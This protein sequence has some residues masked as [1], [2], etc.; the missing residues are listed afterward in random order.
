MNKTKTILAF[1]A[2]GLAT[3]LL[4]LSLLNSYVFHWMTDRVPLSICFWAMLCLAY[5]LNGMRVG[6]VV[7]AGQLLALV[8]LACGIVS[9]FVALPG[10][11]NQTLQVLC[12]V[13][14]GAVCSSSIIDTL[15]ARKA[16]KA[17]AQ[18][19]PAEEAPA[20]EEIAE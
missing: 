13:A 2:I 16:K 19:S 10:W 12:F 5:T 3:G 7:R 1:G 18:E 9:V 11:L 8:L 15:K 20:E 4:A 17:Q 6:K 14:L